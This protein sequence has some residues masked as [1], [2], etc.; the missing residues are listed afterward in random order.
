MNEQQSAFEKWQQLTQQPYVPS[1]KYYRDDGFLTYFNSDVRCVATQLDKNVT[2][3]KDYETKEI[4]GF[5]IRG[6]Y[7]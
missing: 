6:S 1:V 4:I 3:Y 5:K 2:V 7:E